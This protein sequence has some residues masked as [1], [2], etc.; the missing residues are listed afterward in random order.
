[1]SKIITAAA[2]L[3]ALTVAES[4]L[5]QQ[6]PLRANERYCLET[7]GGGGLGGGGDGPLMCRFETMEQCFASKTWVGDRCLLNPW[8]AFR[9][10]GQ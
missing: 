4:A 8:L 7:T 5:A 6:P 1:M 10:R 3:G 9:Q 2:L